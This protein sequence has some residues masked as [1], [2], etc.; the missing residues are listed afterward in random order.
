MKLFLICQQA[1]DTISVFLRQIKHG[2][3]N[4]ASPYQTA[5]TGAVSY[6]S[7]MFSFMFELFVG[8]DRTS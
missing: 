6:G 4:T 5:F 3:A 2:W 1:F 7:E 8:I